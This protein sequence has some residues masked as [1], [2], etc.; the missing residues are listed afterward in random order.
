MVYLHIAIEVY[1]DNSWQLGDPPH[2][3][4]IDMIDILD[5][6]HLT[7]ED[8]GKKRLVTENF[9]SPRDAGSEIGHNVYFC[10]A[11]ANSGSSY[12]RTEEMA[13][14]A[15]AEERGIPEDAN[16]VI[17]NEIAFVQSAKDGGNYHHFSWILLSELIA[18]KDLW[19]NERVE[20]I[21]FITK[22]NAALLEKDPALF[23]ESMVEST[24]SSHPIFY[25]EEDEEIYYENIRTAYPHLVAHR[26]KKSI[27]DFIGKE[28]Y[29]NLVG[30]LISYGEPGK[31]RLTFWLY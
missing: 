6:P 31:V 12:Y 5:R 22:E 17:R 9:A 3:L 8:E 27:M 25:S 19:E 26:W 28:F 30:R 4:E 13:K 21:G 10:N 11:L 14:K 29:D 23:N 1:A 15:L 2:E 16:E 20:M 24:F 18:A 7:V